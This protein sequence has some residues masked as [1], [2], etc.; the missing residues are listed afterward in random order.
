MIKR[1][2]LAN[3]PGHF[4]AHSL[5]SGFVTEAGRR[6]VPPGE[7]MKMTGHK[8]VGVFMGYYRAGDLL[9]SETARMLG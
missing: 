3:L 1:A 8:S 6:Q 7:A 4:S 9:N 2:R 5:R